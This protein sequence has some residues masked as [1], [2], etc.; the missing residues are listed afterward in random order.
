MLVL[1]NVKMT[2]SMDHPIWSPHPSNGK[3]TN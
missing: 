1:Q 3:L 2:V